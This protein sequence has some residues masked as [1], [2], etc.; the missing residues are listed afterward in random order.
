MSGDGHSAARRTR[1]G[2]WSGLRNGAHKT[3]ILMERNV[4]NY[5]RNLLAYGVRAAM[6][7]EGDSGSRRELC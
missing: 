2:L 6:Y 1:K 4:I 7:G 5:S 3:G